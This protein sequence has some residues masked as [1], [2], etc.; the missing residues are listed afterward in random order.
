MH[1]LVAVPPHIKPNSRIH[2]RPANRPLRPRSQRLEV[3]PP[4]PT[5]RPC[6]IW[7]ALATISAPPRSTFGGVHGRSLQGMGSR[8][9]DPAPLTREGSASP[10][11]ETTETNPATTAAALPRTA[12]RLVTSPPQSAVM[13]IV[14]RGH[15]PRDPLGTISCDFARE[16]RGGRGMKNWMGL[17]LGRKAEDGARALEKSSRAIAQHAACPNILLVLVVKRGF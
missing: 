9:R 16:E 6:V 7:R 10:G 4:I 15:L 8:A 1:L 13:D 11:E 14:G 12:R 17:A 5:S 3:V 2:V